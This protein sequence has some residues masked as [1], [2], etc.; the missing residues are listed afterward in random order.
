[1]STIAKPPLHKPP[2]GE[3]RL[4]FAGVGFETYES[5]CRA[6][7]SR[8]AVR[9]AYDGKDLEIMV[10]GPVHDDYG[11]LLDRFIAV[12]A[13]VAGVRRRALG[14]TTWIRPEIRRGIEAD[15]CYMFDPAKLAVVRELLDRKENDVAAYPNPDLAVEIDISRPQAD[16]PG[17]HDRRAGTYAALQVPELWT[18]DGERVTIQQLGE[19]GRYIDTE[20]SRWVPVAASDATRWLVAEDT[21][22]PDAWE[23][24]LRAWAEALP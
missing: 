18:F 5:L 15:Q 12:V 23:D 24:R 20:R 4:A 16:R 11:W 10:T 6:S 7:S 1:L 17:A 8:P 21:D 14:K 19:D 13:R 9:M 2:A 22:D 3:L